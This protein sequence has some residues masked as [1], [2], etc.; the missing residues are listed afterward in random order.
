MLQYCGRRRRWQSAHVD[1][2]VSSVLG[3]RDRWNEI[4]KQPVVVTTVRQIPLMLSLSLSLF[5]CPVAASPFVSL[6]TS[7]FV[8]TFLSIYTTRETDTASLFRN[9]AA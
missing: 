1:S 5:N 3:Y 4:R 7:S 2:R 6:L 8:S 9:Q